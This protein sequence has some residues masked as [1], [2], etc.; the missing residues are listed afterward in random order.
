[1]KHG[2]RIAR[3]GYRREG[4]QSMVEFSLVLPVVLLLLLAIL[5]FGLLFNHYL[6]VTDAARVGARQLALGRGEKETVTGGVTKNPCTDAEAAAIK[7]GGSLNLVA[8]PPPSGSFPAE[9]FSN[10]LATCHNADTIWA[11]GDQVTFTV[12]YPCD[13]TIMGVNFWPGGSCTL[14]ASASEAV[15]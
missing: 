7:S 1:M 12:Q 8:G 2:G 11:Q 6:T 4:G 3:R 5:K 15:E 14:K 10:G 13:L 9:Q